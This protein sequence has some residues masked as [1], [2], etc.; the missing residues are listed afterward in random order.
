MPSA[1]KEMPD[2]EF[3]PVTA[4]RWHDLASLFERHGNPGYCWCMRWR[5]KSAE[6]M[7]L[8]SAGRRNR[9]E[10]LVKGNVPVGILGYLKGQP[11][12]WC[13]IAPREN[14]TLL[15]RSISLSR[16]DDLPAWS[17][18][19]FFVDRKVRGQALSVKLLQAAVAYA[20]SRGATIVEGYPVEPGKSYRFMGSP[21]IFA[22]AGFRAV[23]VARNGRRIVRFVVGQGQRRVRDGVKASKRLK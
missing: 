12:G 22:K 18:V 2:L 17:V 14:Y 10:T 8:K 5:L 9:L 6:F 11:I 20:T 16:I 15:E 7:R 23:A 21:S 19:C 4:D 13:S 3:H 1:K